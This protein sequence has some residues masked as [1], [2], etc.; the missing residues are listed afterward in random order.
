MPGDLMERGMAW[1][2]RMQRRHFAVPVTYERPS[3]AHG[4]SGEAI[5]IDCPAVLGQPG[6]TGE[7]SVAA[8]RID[9]DELDFLIAAADLVHCGRWLEPKPDDRIVF[10]RHGVTRVYEVLPRGGGPP[11]RWS[12]PQKTIARIHAKLSE[13]IHG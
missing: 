4:E 6:A 2:A 1:L 11:W 12:D 8:I 3:G 9:A 10:T 13:E 7:E 5:R